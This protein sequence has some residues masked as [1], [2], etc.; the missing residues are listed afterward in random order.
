MSTCDRPECDTG[1]GPYEVLGGSPEQVRLQPC[2]SC[3][4][5]LLVGQQVFLREDGIA[6]TVCAVPSDPYDWCRARTGET[7]LQTRERMLASIPAGLKRNTV[8]K[9]P[10]AVYLGVQTWGGE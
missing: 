3:G 7:P 9:D 5:P 4:E 6:H 1:P 2:V 10:A 8:S